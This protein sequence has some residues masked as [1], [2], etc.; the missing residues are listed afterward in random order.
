M[1]NLNSNKIIYITLVLLSFFFMV[2]CE[3]YLDKAPASDI[4]DQEVFQDFFSFQG[5]VEELYQ[6]IPDYSK[7]NWQGEHNLAD[8]ILSTQ[9][10]FMNMHFDAG[11]YWY[12]QDVTWSFFNKANVTIEGDLRFKGLWP[13]AWYAIRKANLG[14]KN[15]ELLANATQEEKDAIKGQLLFFRGFYYFELMRA[16]G[17]LPYID[18][19]LN[20]NQPLDYPRLNYRETALLAAKDLEGAA[21]LLPADWDVAEVGKR[22]LGEN[23]QRLTKPTAYGYL[24]KDLLYAASPLMNQ[25]STGNASF[26]VELCKQA[27]EAFGKSIK[28]SEEQNV[29]NLEP[30]GSYNDLFYTLSAGGSRLPG[31]RET[32]LRPLNWVETRSRNTQANYYNIPALGGVNMTPCPTHNY[33]KYFGMANGLPLD[34]PD[35]GYDPA[36]PWGNRDPRFY[37]SIIVDG[38]QIVVVNNA[39][40]KPNRFLLSYNGGAHRG[41]NGT[42]TGYL[43]RKFIGITCNKFDNSYANAANYEQTCA[44]M[45]LSD[46]YLMYAEAVL[47]GYG[48][49]NSKSQVYNL[50]AE[51]AVNKVR[52]RAGVPSL[53]SRF[54]TGGNKGSFM[55]Q[56]IRER[57][58]ELAFEGHRWFDLRRWLLAGDKKYLDKTEIRF[59]RGSNGKPINMQEVVYLTR[60]FETKHNWLPLPID[61]VSIYPE[62]GQNPG[63]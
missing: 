37:K 38:D 17:G 18:T 33:Q 21:N 40:S 13:N 34:E 35:S 42:I 1:K 62:F 29:Y 28:I 61:Q 51:Q 46:V 41:T 19:L 23:R 8:E 12:W 56:I 58:V 2:S 32:M 57:A 30:W 47:Q 59:D 63:W 53:D 52:N 6:S 27:A 15:F 31:G 24:G 48:T 49:Y 43:E 36:N 22:T 20:A 9:P 11:D 5:F 60:V 7:N 14:L 39:S 3:D 26:D 44:F 45:R 55:E 10:Q 25:E 4:T 16:W 54:T 50:T